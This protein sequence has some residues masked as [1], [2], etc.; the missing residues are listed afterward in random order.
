MSFAGSFDPE[1]RA[2]RATVEKA[3]NVAASEE[4]EVQ[5]ALSAAQHVY[6]RP[7]RL[8]QK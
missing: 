4:F 6:P 2:A 8:W 7:V 3:K 5:L 1:A